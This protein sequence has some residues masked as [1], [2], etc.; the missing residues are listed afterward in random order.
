MEGSV[1][2]TKKKNPQPNYSSSLPSLGIA[3]QKQCM[4]NLTNQTYTY[5]PYTTPWGVNKERV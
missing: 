2:G 3:T 4:N 5:N 1:A